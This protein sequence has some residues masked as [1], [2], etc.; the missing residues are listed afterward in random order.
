MSGTS[1]H[2]PLNCL[3]ITMSSCILG[4]ATASSSRAKCHFLSKGFLTAP[5]LPPKTNYSSHCVVMTACWPGLPGFV[6]SDTWLLHPPVSQSLTHITHLCI[7]RTEPLWLLNK[8]LWNES[9]SLSFFLLYVNESD[10][11]GSEMSL[12]L[13]DPWKSLTSELPWL[14][15]KV[16]VPIL[17]IKPCV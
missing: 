12:I 1:Q 2:P 17:F 15:A 5:M 9:S 14:S 6:H 10:F 8:H 16:P 3:R 4:H 11:S 7:P 13:L